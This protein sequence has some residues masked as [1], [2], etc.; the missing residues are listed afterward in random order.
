[1]L[2]NYAKISAVY[3][4]ISLLQ[5]IPLLPFYHHTKNPSS[6]LGSEYNIKYPTSAVNFQQ[7]F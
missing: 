5:I 2:Q 6:E 7:H 4:R 1:M 3:L